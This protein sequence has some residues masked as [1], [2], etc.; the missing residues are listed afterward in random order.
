MVY[1]EEE[2]LQSQTQQ[3]Q[4]LPVFMPNVGQV[5]PMQMQWVASPVG[6]PVATGNQQPCFAVMPMPQVMNDGQAPH[7]Q[8]QTLCSKRHEYSSCDLQALPA[9]RTN[10]FDT[11]PAL[12]QTPPQPAQLRQHLEEQRQSG[13]RSPG[14]QGTMHMM[15]VPYPNQSSDQ[16][17][18]QQCGQFNH[19][20]EDMRRCNGDSSKQAAIQMMM[21]MQQGLPQNNGDV[22]WRQPRER[23]APPWQPQCGQPRSQTNVAWQPYQVPHPSWPSVGDW[24]SG[25]VP[26]YASHPEPNRTHLAELAHAQPFVPGGE[27]YLGHDTHRSG[28]KQQMRTNTCM[29]L[30]RQPFPPGQF[31]HEMSKPT[32]SKH[33]DGIQAKTYDRHDRE[34]QGGTG[35]APAVEHMPLAHGDCFSS[36]HGIQTK[37]VPGMPP[38]GGSDRSAGETM[39]AQLQ[40]LQYEDENAVCIA[41]RINKLGFSSAE[42][43]RAYFSRYGPVKHVHVS[44]SR[45]KSL[46]RFGGER[47]CAESHWRLR[48]AA[49]GFVVMMSP[50]ATRRILAD[51]PDHRINGVT[52]RLQSFHRRE[53]SDAE[54]DQRQFA[55]SH[56]DDLDVEDRGEQIY[57]RWPSPGSDADENIGMQYPQEMPYAKGS[58][59]LPE[60]DMLYDTIVSSGGPILYSG[61][62]KLGN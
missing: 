45:V 54:D 6:S 51:G 22:E 37:P 20:V 27:C 2:P 30:P 33:R 61:Q 17:L 9:E 39:K 12:Q 14:S 23:R 34:Q 48:A 4:M 55:D 32:R 44:H 62:M 43:L 10:S 18:T 16:A 25:D 1:L 3:S 40:A 15:M 59:G 29:E 49:L 47:R 8:A 13:G 28:K 11:M 5:I 19:F 60:Y 41:R 46:K 52:V 53:S 36:G 58:K 56:F 57:P 50:D 26:C 24:A 38:L 35:H 31:D 7:E 21:P 42:A